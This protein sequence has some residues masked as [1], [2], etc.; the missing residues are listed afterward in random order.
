MSLSIG[1]K[2]KTN[3]ERLEMELTSAC[4]H[5]CAHC[6][7][8][9][10]ANQHTKKDYPMGQLDTSRYMEMMSKAVFESGATHLTL[11]GGEPLLRKDVMEIVAHA[12]KLVPS[13]RLVTNG[14]HISAT[15][16]TV[17]KQHNV[18]SIQVTLLSQNR[19]TH[20][21]L[22]GA[23]CFDDTV[24]AVVDVKEAGILVNVCFV[25]MKENCAEFEGVL[26]L[27]YALGIRQIA[28]NRMSPCGW[29]VDDIERLMP[30]P[31]QIEHNLRTANNIGP[32]YGIK[33]VT[34]MPIP[35]CLIRIQKYKNI[36]FGFCSAGSEKPNYV[37]DPLGNVRTCNLSSQ[38]LGNILEQ[39]FQ[40]IVKHKYVNELGRRV[41][42]MCLGC[43]YEKRC[44]GGCK[45][46]GQAT[47]GTLDDPDPFV[48]LALKSMPDEK[49]IL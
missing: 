45:E 20:N 17:L 26:E 12:G 34:A 49:V 18:K 16:A 31:E 36:K 29:A 44:R 35:P 47:Y 39:S 24:R 32:K 23:S 48:Q 14:S 25:A 19:D 15:R 5:R 8:V 27:A 40:K 46:S 28:Y 3:V 38:I 9:W 13:V 21:R 2:K 43:Y 37:I 4:D 1:L 30:T 10:N 7:V 41:P 11:T 42:K 22:K 6:Y 33:V